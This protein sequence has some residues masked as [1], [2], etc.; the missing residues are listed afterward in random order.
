[1]L[2]TATDNFQT[3][4]NHALTT[5]SVFDKWDS[6]KERFN[7]SLSSFKNSRLRLA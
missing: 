3:G 1:M 6:P 5:P 2:E 7:L 4:Y